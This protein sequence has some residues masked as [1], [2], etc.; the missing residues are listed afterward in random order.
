MSKQAKKRKKK[1]TTVVKIK[2]KSVSK[3]RI[4]QRLSTEDVEKMFMVYVAKPVLRTVA[5]TLHVSVP[6]VRKYRDREKWDERREKILRDVRRKDGNEI[7][8]ALTENL[9]V[10]RFA[11]AILVK[12]IQTKKAK[13]R[14]TYAEL[15]RMI[16]LEGFLLGQPDSRTAV[17]RFEHLTDEQLNEKLEALTAFRE[18]NE[19]V[20]DN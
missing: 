5:D 19:P 17:G 2:R 18:Q 20:N 9:K 15:D 13:S 4:G 12:K 3:V 10:V 6:T 8:K 7:A 11:K 16:R 14:S 1:S